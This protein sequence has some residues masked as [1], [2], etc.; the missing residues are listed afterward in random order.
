MAKTVMIVDDEAHILNI[1]KFN[2][3]RSGYTILTAGN[4][5]AALDLI[6]ATPP[7][8][9]LCDV[10]MP[11]MTGLELCTILKE[12]ETTRG[13][14]FVILTAKGQQVDENHGME[15]GADAY[16]TKPFSPK[17]VIQKVKEMLGE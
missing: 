2:L 6:H 11:I 13:I 12:D 4:G 14:P 17:M 9:V 1:L 16:L 8:L 7:D 3:I 10:M 15:I 5:K